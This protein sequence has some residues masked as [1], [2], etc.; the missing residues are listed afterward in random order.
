MR[1]AGR[2]SAAIDVLTDMEARHRPASE[3]LR[4]WG[5]SH[6]FAG[7]GDRAAIGNLVYDGLR[8]RSSIGW[9]MGGETPW[10]LAV[11]AA[12]FA[13]GASP[14]EL[15]DSFAAEPHA[16]APLPDDL[17]TRLEATDLAQAPGY[18][19]ADLPEWIAPQFEAAF[20]PEWVLEGEALAGRPPLDLR[21]NTLKAERD[22]V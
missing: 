18:V 20:G 5:V 12:L 13:W 1:L 21:V 16:P 19:R 10:D 15:N 9:R 14:R 3:A 7:A 8:Q 2:I 4:D 22:K 11:G 6:R 17:L